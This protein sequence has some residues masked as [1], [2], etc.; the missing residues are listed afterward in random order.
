MGQPQPV[1]CVHNLVPR[2]KECAALIHTPGH[3][4]VTAHNH[5]VLHC[6]VTYTLR[7]RHVCVAELL[8]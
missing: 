1:E 5:T 7:T 4:Q 8:L 3:L 2:A 6:A